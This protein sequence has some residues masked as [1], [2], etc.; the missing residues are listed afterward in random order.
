MEKITI[1]DKRF[2]ICMT[3]QEIDKAV[4][5]VAEKLDNDLKDVDTP[6]FLSVSKV[7]SRASIFCSACSRRC[8]NSSIVI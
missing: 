5:A 1:H 2:K 7:S 6:I 4:G 8:A 3:A